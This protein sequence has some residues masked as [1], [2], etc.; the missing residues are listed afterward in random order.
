MKTLIYDI[1]IG[2]KYNDAYQRRMYTGYID[3]GVRMSAD[4]SCLT[5]FGY[6]WLGE[7]RTYCKDLTDFPD[8]GPNMTNEGHLVDFVA[9]LFKEADHLVAHYGDKFDRRYMNA[10]FLEYGH[11]PITPAPILKQSDTCKLA[12]THLKISANKLDNLARFLKVPFKRTKNWP[13]DWLLMTKG[14]VGAFKRVKTYCIGDII[15][16]E[17][18][19]KKLQPFA[20]PPNQSHIKREKCCVGCGGDNYIKYGFVYNKQKVWDRFACK[21]CGRVFNASQFAN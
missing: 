18:V 9:K 8:F 16:L 13:D 12:K 2:H 14:N 3:T 5:H 15:A 6:K 21:D 17:A 1:E 4:I 20:K 11:P 10:K 7:N 19:Y